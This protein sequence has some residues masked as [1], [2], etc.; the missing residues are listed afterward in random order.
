MRKKQVREV[1]HGAIGAWEF[2]E[3]RGGP[4]TYIVKHRLLVQASGSLT[5]G[6]SGEVA[7]L[8]T[9]PNAASDE[10]RKAFFEIAYVVAGKASHKGR[11]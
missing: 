10:E 9:I 11:V 2:P 5:A 6:G 8:A 4:A 1:V 3:S 7:V